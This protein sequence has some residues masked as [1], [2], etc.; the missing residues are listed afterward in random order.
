MFVQITKDMDLAANREAQRRNPYIKHHF[1]VSHLTG[2]ERDIIGFL[3]EFA[4]Q[5]FLGLSWNDNIRDN[6][7]TID[8]GDGTVN[9]ISFDVK[10]E[11]I[12]NPYFRYVLSRSINDDGVYGRRLINSGQANL[13]HKYNIVIFGQFLRNDYTRWYPIGYLETEFK[14]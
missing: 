9:G 14:K 3:G 8:S 10:T 6:Y 12:P 11:T 5:Q 1:E 4:A 13:L 2:N 7:Y